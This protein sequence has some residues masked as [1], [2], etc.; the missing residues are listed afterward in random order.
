M[1]HI[2]TNLELMFHSLEEAAVWAASRPVFQPRVPFTAMAGED[3]STP[4]I[5][6]ALGLH[7]CVTAIGVTGVFRRCLNA[8]PDAKSY[9]NDHEAYPIMVIKFKDDEGWTVPSKAQVPDVEDT[10]E[11]WLLKPARPEKIYIKW[12]DACSIQMKDGACRTV[13]SA[14]K[15]LKD[16]S[17]YDHPW[18][19]GKGHPLDC[20]HMGNDPWPET[21]PVLESL[22]LDSRLGGNVGFATPAWPLDGSWNFMPLDPGMS[23]YRTHFHD[24]RRFSGFF[25]SD[26]TPVFEGYVLKWGPDA[27]HRRFGTV[28]RDNL[29]GWHVEPWSGG[30]PA[31][32]EPGPDRRLPGMAVHIGHG[33][34]EDPKI[35][36]SLLPRE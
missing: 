34:L 21:D 20:P 17:G 14:L 32:L 5:C 35:P 8:N 18:L 28:A 33:F 23:P 7:G 2:M 11:R 24:L 27:E 36:T 19:N 10:G 12:L 4:R 13:C 6:G 1:Y 30:A 26:G 3:L 9:E 29:T 22:Y 16:L 25:D 31:A 15:F